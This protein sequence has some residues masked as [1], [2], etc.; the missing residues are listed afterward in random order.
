MGSKHTGL[1]TTK[2]KRLHY[3]SM[4]ARYGKRRA[5]ACCLHEVANQNTLIFPLY[6]A[7]IN[8]S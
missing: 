1:Q 8:V 7:E 2:P 4:G 3:R 5:W 6:Q